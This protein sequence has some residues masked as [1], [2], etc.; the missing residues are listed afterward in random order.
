MRALNVIIG[1]N[2]AGKSNLVDALS[3]LRAV[4]K[5]LPLPIRRGGG[6]KDWLWRGEAPSDRAELEILTGEGWVTEGREKGASVRY[7]MVFGAAGDSFVV[8]DERLENEH[9]TAGGSKPYFYFGYERGRPML[10]VKGEHREL[11]RAD[12]DPTQSILS[13]RRDP[14]TYPEVTRLADQLGRILIYRNWQ[15]GPD[16]VLRASCAGDVR[17]DLLS[18]DCDNLPVRLAALMRS[19]VSKRR[20]VELLGKL[21]QGFDDLVVVSEGG[22]Q[23]LYLHEGSMAV[24]AGRL[25]DGT[26]RY[27]CLLAILLDAGAAPLVVIEEPEL[28]LHPDMLPTIRDLL[29]EASARTQLVV[30]T[31]S[32]QL[33]DAMTEQAES[34]L[35]CEKHEGA[36]V[37]TRLQQADVDCRREQGGLGRLWMDGHLGGTRW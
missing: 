12:I 11:Q 32:T 4:P 18:E 34:V 8:L 9:A 14:D 17:G 27:L 36:T 25:S 21:A 29:V 7:R 13:Q 33:V 35:V 10:N 31:H 15:F 1:P 16:S 37:M 26:L 22:Q 3:V 28:G 19:P 2:G 24:P 6:V 5:D 23:H 30:T 20:L